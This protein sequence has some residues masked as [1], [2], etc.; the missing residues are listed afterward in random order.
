MFSSMHIYCIRHCARS[1]GKNFCESLRNSQAETPLRGK[2]G[3]RTLL[4]LG[5]GPAWADSQLELA[6]G[7]GD[8]NHCP[9]RK[10]TQEAWT[11]HSVREEGQLGGELK[12]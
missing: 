8:L 1:S 5:L 2:Q 11:A 7:R 3:P 4:R 12:E 9:W 10:E 6:L